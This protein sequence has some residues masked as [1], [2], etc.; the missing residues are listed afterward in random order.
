MSLYKIYKK[1]KFSKNSAF[2]KENGNKTEM[3]NLII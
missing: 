1:L 2:F 3:Y